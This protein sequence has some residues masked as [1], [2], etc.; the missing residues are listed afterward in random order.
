MSCPKQT[1]TA[2]GEVSHAYM[3]KSSLRPA[4]GSLGTVQCRSCGADSECSR[5]MLYQ[6]HKTQTNWLERE[7]WADMFSERLRDC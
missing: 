4:P 3:G 7:G 6:S 1:R 2:G 5:E